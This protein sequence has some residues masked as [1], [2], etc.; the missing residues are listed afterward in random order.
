MKRAAVLRLC[1]ILGV[2]ASTSFAT[3]VTIF[4]PNQYVRTTGSPDVFTDSFTAISGSGMLIVKNGAIDGNSRISDAISS[5]SVYVNGEQIFGTSDFN[6]N[7]YL[8][9]SPVNLLENNSITVEL[10]SS[11]GSYL[12][13]EVTQQVDPPTVSLSADPETIL[14]GESATLTWS[15]T[16]ADTCVIEP[17]IGTVDVNG[18]IQVSPTETTT[19]TITATSLGGTATASITITANNPSTP[20]TVQLNATPTSIGQ[21]GSATLSWTSSNSQSAFI[22]NGVG[23]VSVNG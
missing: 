14:L 13:I 8:L 17:G 1:L 20:P 23:I 15:S 11:P 21:G 19:Y 18:S 2:F 12:S 7:V 3:E 5:A 22:D 10:A 4:G 9:Q 6:Q 16:T